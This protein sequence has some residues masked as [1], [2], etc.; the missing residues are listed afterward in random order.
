MVI[1]AHVLK[2]QKKHH[3]IFPKRQKMTANKINE[4]ILKEADNLQ[5]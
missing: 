2:E 5:T 3:T 4:A 1:Q